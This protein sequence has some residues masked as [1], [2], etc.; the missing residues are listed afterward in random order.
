MTT[1]F[2]VQ[3]Q[4]MLNIIFGFSMCYPLSGNL[5]LSCHGERV[6]QAKPALIL[7]NFL[8]RKKVEARPAGQK[9]QQSA[10]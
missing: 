7:C 2:H 4:R 10:K 3:G 5:P 9:Q 1:N 6:K 8:I